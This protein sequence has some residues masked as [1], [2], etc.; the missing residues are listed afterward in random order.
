MAGPTDKL[1][2]FARQVNGDNL[3]THLRPFTDKAVD[4]SPSVAVTNTHY[5]VSHVEIR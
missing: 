2:V 1:L 5:S 4:H 3:T